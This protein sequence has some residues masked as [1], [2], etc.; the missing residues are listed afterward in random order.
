MS[1]PKS[2]LGSTARTC[3]LIPSLLD[4]FARGE[5]LLCC[6]RTYPMSRI[7]IASIVANTDIFVATSP[8]PASESTFSPQP[9]QSRLQGT[10]PPFASTRCHLRL[11]CCY[12]THSP[13]CTTQ[14]VIV[15]QITGVCSRHPFLLGTLVLSIHR[16]MTRCPPHT[17]AHTRNRGNRCARPAVIAIVYI[18]SDSITFIA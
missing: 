1:G 2:H 5:R 13:L 11:P 18:S 17:H 6:G 9:H 7:A 15:F 8:C 10:Q 14:M 4:C 3:F 16:R 12:V